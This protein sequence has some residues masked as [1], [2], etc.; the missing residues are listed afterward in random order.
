MTNYYMN[1]FTKTVLVIVI[2]LLLSERAFSQDEYPREFT[3]PE[4]LI[5]FNRD[6]PFQDAIQVIDQYSQEFTG[7]FIIDRSDFDG[8]ININLPAMHWR[9]ALTYILRVQNMILDEG[10]DYFEILTVQQAADRD[11]DGTPADGSEPG[12]EGVV[13]TSTR[14][15]EVRI[16]A[17]FFEGNRR[18]LQ[19][20]GV[21]WSTLTNAV[22]SNILDYI[23]EDG[24]AQLPA[25][26]FSNRFVQVNASGAQSVSQNIF[27]SLINFGDVG[28]GIEVQAL[29][30]AFEADNLGETLATPTIKVMDGEVGRIQ[31]G[32]DFSIKQRDIAGN[33]TDTFFSTGTILEVTPQV[34]E[35]Q[36]TTFIYLDL[37]VERSTAQPDPVSTIINK[38]DASTHTL[39][40]DGESTVIAGLYRTDRSEVRRGVPILKDLPA[41]FFGLRY[42]FGYNSTDVSQS[43]LIVI[44]QAELEESIPVRMA[45]QLRTRREAYDQQQEFHR[46]GL[47]YVPEVRSASQQTGSVREPEPDP[48]ITGGENLSPTNNIQSS[49]ETLPAERERREGA[50]PSTTNP[51]A[52]TPEDSPTPDSIPEMK[53]ETDTTSNPVSGQITSENLEIEEER[54]SIYPFYTIGGSFSEQENAER[55][56]DK[57]TNDGFDAHLLVNTRNTLYYVAYAGFSEA[58]DAIEF[59]QEI[60]DRI[61]SDAWLSR[62]DTFSR[63]E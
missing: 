63:I 36:D 35:Y 48:D 8:P 13:G 29:F 30:S 37:Q 1:N 40:L 7:K 27:N 6:T 9:D 26:E 15:R 59:T 4:E 52:E 12:G 3:S 20:I 42:L 62:I 24:N 21:D 33:V 54:P 45:E 19:E 55:F 50:S 34:I 17:T 58:D 47:D 22:P 31:V 43:E 28:A 49:E 16:N 18:A 60:Q 46:A 23:A 32:Q 57:L 38:E 56:Y 44:V 2:G 61:Q 25:T 14:T 5:S 39:L 53:Q 11:L 51:S 10:P 41:W